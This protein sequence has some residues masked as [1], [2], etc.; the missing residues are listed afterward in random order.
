MKN[1]RRLDRYDRSEWENDDE[2]KGK[3]L[4][5]LWILREDRRD[6]YDM[7]DLGIEKNDFYETKT[8]RIDYFAFKEY[9]VDFKQY[10]DSYKNDFEKMAKDY[11]RL[12]DMKMNNFDEFI[13]KKNCN[14]SHFLEQNFLRFR[15]H[16]EDLRPDR[17]IEYC[18]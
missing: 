9:S 2:W 4:A 13:L 14:R 3:R 10:E 7:H 8:S 12:Q 11:I 17:D 6:L 5:F 18:I 16:H 15:W 1:Y